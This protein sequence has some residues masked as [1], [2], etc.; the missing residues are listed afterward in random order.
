VK[1]GN[2]ILL[3]AASLLVVFTA[4][5][6]QP[7]TQK[8]P[9]VEWEGNI[10]I[11]QYNFTLKDT[12]KIKDREVGAKV[13]L[14]DGT[15]YQIK[16]SNGYGYETTEEL[17]NHEVIHTY[18]PEYRHPDFTKPDV[19]RHNDPVYRLQD[20]TDLSVCNQLINKLREKQRG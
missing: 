11:E 7:E 4:L 18:F 8:N 3:A 6:L 10:Q 1:K 20:N 14:G 16:I 13:K 9:Q 15:P 17:C 2:I 5:T 19:H 12:V